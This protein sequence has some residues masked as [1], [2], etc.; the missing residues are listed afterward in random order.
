MFTHPPVTAANAYIVFFN[1]IL[2]PCT[3]FI[4]NTLKIMLI[5]TIFCGNII[6]IINCLLP[7]GIIM[8][9]LTD[10]DYASR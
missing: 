10:F 2:S 9:I 3:F 1:A 8:R 7:M 5:K 4:H 6:N